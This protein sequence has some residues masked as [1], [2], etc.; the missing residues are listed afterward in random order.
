MGFPP[1]SI[2]TFKDFCYLF[3]QLSCNSLLPICTIIL[4]PDFVRTCVLIYR[5]KEVGSTFPLPVPAPRGGGIFCSVPTPR[6]P[7]GNPIL[8]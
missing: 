1:L 5:L 6:G 7:Y 8:H 2:L 4:M 3:V